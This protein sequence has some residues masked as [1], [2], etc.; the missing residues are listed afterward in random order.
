MGLCHLAAAILDNKLAGLVELNVE[1]RWQVNKAQMEAPVWFVSGIF[2]F[3]L[4][5]VTPATLGA[6]LASY[7]PASS[8]SLAAD[9]A[10]HL[11]PCHKSN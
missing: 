10:G 4:H 6:I 2:F 3:P 5:L 1:P 11:S 8:A 7:A 9:L